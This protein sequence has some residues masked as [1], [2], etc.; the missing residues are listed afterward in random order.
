MCSALQDHP[1]YKFKQDLISLYTEYGSSRTQRVVQN[2]YDQWR[3]LSH[4]S[5]DHFL[6]L[7]DGQIEVP[8]GVRPK[9]SEARF[10]LRLEKLV[11]ADFEAQAKGLTE[12]CVAAHRKVLDY[13]TLSCIQC[14]MTGAKVAD[15]IPQ[16]R[17]WFKEAVNALS[18]STPTTSPVLQQYSETTSSGYIASIVGN[19]APVLNWPKYIGRAIRTK[20]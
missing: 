4:C 2:Y 8:K 13:L 14:A 11:F 20:S 7:I 10:D 5:M 6:S 16:Q 1:E 18:E 12:L 3:K 9:K 19:P 15:R 17:D